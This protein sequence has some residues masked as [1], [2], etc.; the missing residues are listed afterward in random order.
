MMNAVVFFM[1]FLTVTVGVAA[2][3]SINARGEEVLRGMRECIEHQERMRREAEERA[4]AKEQAERDEQARLAR[5]RAAQLERARIARQLAAE[6]DADRVSWSSRF[7][8]SPWS[9][10]VFDRPARRGID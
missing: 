3:A 10:L 1:L 5:R 8:A 4:R 9:S 2:L 7:P 6:R